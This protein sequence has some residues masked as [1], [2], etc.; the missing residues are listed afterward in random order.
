MIQT[1]GLH[2][3]AERVFWGRPNVPGEL[4]GAA[5]RSAK[6][7]PI[8]FRFQRGIYALYAGYELVY[9]GQTGA[10]NDRLFKRL[11]D[12]RRDH[13]SERW[14][15]FS[16]FGTQWVTKSGELSADTARLGNSVE[17]T[18]NILEAV[19]IAIAEPR[20]NLQRGKW[21]EATKYFQWWERQEDEDSEE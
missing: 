16:W 7:R 20:L 15:R 11:K 13:L 19:G 5:S 9:V 2:W 6:A 21:G 10:G 14:D 4:L 1:Y 18:L 8:D 12:H 3:H 17:A